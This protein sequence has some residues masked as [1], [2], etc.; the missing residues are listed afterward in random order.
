MGKIPWKRAW[1]PTSVFL[2]GKLHEQRSLAGYSPWG[3]KKSDTAERLNTHT[4]SINLS[5]YQYLSHIGFTHL[6]IIYI[7][8]Y[9]SN[10]DYYFLVPQEITKDF[11]RRE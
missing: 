10:K 11:K 3:R 5:I 7:Y 9:L 6:P 4:M 1:Q 8:L 2:P